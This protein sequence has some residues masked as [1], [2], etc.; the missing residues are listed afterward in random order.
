MKVGHADEGHNPVGAGGGDAVGCGSTRAG[1]GGALRRKD[2]G[3][4]GPGSSARYSEY[5]QDRPAFGPAAS[6]GRSIS[7]RDGQGRQVGRLLRQ[8]SRDSFA[9]LLPVP[10]S[11]HG[12]S[13]WPGWCTRDGE[14]DTWQRLPGRHRE[15][16]P[17]RDSGDRG[18]Q[19]GNLC[20]ALWPVGHGRWLALPDRRTTRNQS[21]GTGGRFWL[22]A[23]ASVPQASRLCSPTPARS[24]W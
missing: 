7:R 19:K 18:G 20:K 5:G 16:R 17:S 15:Y 11:V 21:F 4:P 22:R 6:L 1:P 9:G 23:S 3:R 12:R 14:P 10:D 13:E 24:K 2:H 8:G